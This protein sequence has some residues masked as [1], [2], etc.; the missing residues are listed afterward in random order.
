MGSG[1][2][3]VSAVRNGYVGVGIEYSREYAELAKRR[4]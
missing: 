1:T 2:S 3:I 4:L